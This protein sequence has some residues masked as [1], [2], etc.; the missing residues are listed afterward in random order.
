[1][2]NFYYLCS[3][4]LIEIFSHAGVKPTSGRILVYKA[5]QEFN[6]AF[7]LADLEN[8]LLSMDK[9]TIFRAITLFHDHHLIH[10]VNDGSGS[11]KYCLCHN[12][13]NCTDEEMHCHFYCTRCHQTYCLDES[14]IPVA[15]VPEGFRVQSINYVMRG[16]CPHCRL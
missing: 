9:S 16:L 6:R 5:M 14:P 2:Q 4:E 11:Q 15:D 12:H 7:S 1:M 13:G 8:A 10:E 3:M